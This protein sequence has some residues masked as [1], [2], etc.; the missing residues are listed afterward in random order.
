[1][2]LALGLALTPLAAQA[3][4]KQSIDQGLES[5]REAGG[6]AWRGTKEAAREAADKLPDLTDRALDA[7]NDPMG[8]EQQPEQP[9]SEE[10]L[11]EERF[12]QVWDDL[13]KKL[14][15]GVEM[16]DRIDKAPESAFFSADKPSLRRD[17]NEILD[18]T[19]VLLEDR[20]IADLQN[21][22]AEHQA[23]IEE[24]RANIVKYREARL[25]APKLHVVKVTRSGYDR[26][27]ADEEQI[28]ANLEAEI[29]RIQEDFRQRMA[30]IGVTLTPEQTRT[31]LARVDADDIVRMAAVFD[32]LKQVTAQLA[33]LMAASG[34]AVAQSRRYYGMHVVLLEMMAHMQ[35]QYVEQI[36][37]RYL[38]RLAELTAKTESV[39]NQS[40]RGLRA[41][42]NPQR[43][44]VYE[45]NLEAQKLT[46]KTARLYADM[47][48]QQR[49]QVARARAAVQKDLDLARNTY[50]TVQLSAD[51]LAMLKTSMESYRA[52]TSLQAPRITPFENR[53]MREKFAELSKLLSND[54]G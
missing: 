10:E 5:A 18:D 32:T 38:A 41:E 42:S 36:D 25:T 45:R 17:L 2:G 3:D 51:L 16:L 29:T 21:K 11:R 39:R 50:A 54:N 52:L 23:R 19:V 12:R 9:P 4:W 15:D 49:G 35:D 7:L 1:M 22:I 47:L 27:I 34:E 46:L 28:I 31:L 37:Q 53:M 14:D 6:K 44:A 26:M 43:R 24:A 8:K 20:S 33:E 40:A 13:L 30:V 48:K